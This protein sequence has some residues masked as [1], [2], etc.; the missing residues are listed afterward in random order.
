MKKICKVEECERNLWARG[1]CLMHYKHWWRHGDVSVV[2]CSPNGNRKTHP[3]YKTYCEMRARCYSRRNHA[4]RDYGGRGILICDRWLGV[5]GF[6]NFCEDM[7][8]RPQG[9][10]IE[11]IDNNKGYSPSNC[12]WATPKEQANNRRMRRDSPIYRL[13]VN[14]VLAEVRS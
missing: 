8:P 14:S 2:K 10:Y 12:K 4:Y 9:Y 6:T 13:A 5:Q 3:L 1:W 11:R 7:E